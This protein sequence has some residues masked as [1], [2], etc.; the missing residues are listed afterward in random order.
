MPQA[1]PECKKDCSGVELKAVC[2][3]DTLAEEF[4]TKDFESECHLE[5]HNCENKQSSKYS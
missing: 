5:M 1:D 2:G 4:Q 3:G